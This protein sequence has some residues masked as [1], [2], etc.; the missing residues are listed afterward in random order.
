MTRRIALL[1]ALAASTVAIHAAEERVVVLKDGGALTIRPNGNMV[2][3]D[4]AGH[5]VRMRDG[6]TMEAKDG[7]RYVMRNDLA[8]KQFI[9]KGSL[10][11]KL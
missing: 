11:P 3:V 8:W 2:H 9:E 7:A 5:R 6:V 1:I 10:N 4:A